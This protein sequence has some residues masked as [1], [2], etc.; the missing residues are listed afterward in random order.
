LDGIPLAIELAAA[1]V[2]SLTV[3]EI[4]A[5]LDD[6][7]ALLTGGARTQPRHQTLRAAMDWSWGLLTETQRTVLRRLSIFPAGWTLEAAEAVCQQDGVTET[8]DDPALCQASLPRLRVLDVVSALVDRSQVVFE[9]EKENGRYRLLETVRQYA[10]ERLQ[11]PEGDA[12]ASRHAAFYFELAEGWES[13]YGKTMGLRV[14]EAEYANL[15]GALDWCLRQAHWGA[16]AVNAAEGVHA[17]WADCRHP[18]DGRAWWTK[19]LAQK[20]WVPDA[21]LPKAQRCAGE[22]AFRCRDWEP[23]RSLFQSAADIARASGETKE[24][25]R[26]TIHLGILERMQY[27]L[28]SAGASGAERGLA[29]AQRLL[30]EGLALSRAAGCERCT[31]EA[32]LELAWV[33]ESR[34]DLCQA[35]AHAEEATALYRKQGNSLGTARA[36]HTTGVVLRVRGERSRARM[37][38]EESL[39]LSAALGDRL[40]ESWTLSDLARLARED[41]RTVDARR[42]LEASVELRRAIDDRVGVAGGLSELAFLALDEEDPGRARPLLEESLALRRQHG[43]RIGAARMLV[44][45]GRA[46]RDEGRVADALAHYEEALRLGRELGHAWVCGSSLK[47]MGLAKDAMRVP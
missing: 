19:A 35:Q 9:P 1:R 12:V 38:F 22:L 42:L 15:R 34:G 25:A 29:V 33:L 43:D 31:A 45:L 3:H 41:G 8:E 30:E 47:G 32:M 21:L 5:R 17:L 37:L 46:A 44:Y 18:A 36:L 23:A 16:R 26:A 7:L 4:D 24:L 28:G 39:A 11:T 40:F 6:R 2:R 20:G 14:L 10:R 13:R 27:D